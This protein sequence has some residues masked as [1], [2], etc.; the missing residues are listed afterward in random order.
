MGLVTRGAAPLW[1]F[2]L[3]ASYFPS[4][5]NLKLTSLVLWDSRTLVLGLVGGQKGEFSNLLIY[6][7][8][9]SIV[10]DP[11]PSLVLLP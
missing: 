11:L 10:S 3:L 4:Q 2:R 9:Y 8:Y 5:L 6:L 1:I 7:C